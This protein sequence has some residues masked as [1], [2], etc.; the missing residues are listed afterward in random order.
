MTDI[1]SLKE[2]YY[3]LKISG[4]SQWE[5]MYIKAGKIYL[6]NKDTHAYPVKHFTAVKEVS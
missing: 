5:K 2:G 3:L 1:K 4:Y 6:N